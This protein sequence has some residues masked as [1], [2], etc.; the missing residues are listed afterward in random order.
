MQVFDNMSALLEYDERRKK[1]IEEFM[2]NGVMFSALDVDIDE[3][4]E[5]G[6]GT[7]I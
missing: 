1:I 7:E 4:A 3:S 5:I 6:E 2:A